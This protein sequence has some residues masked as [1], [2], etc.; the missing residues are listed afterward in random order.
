MNITNT[1]IWHY[2]YSNDGTIWEKK[3]KTVAPKR[4]RCVRR[5]LTSSLARSIVEFECVVVRVPACKNGCT[6]QSPHSVCTQLLPLHSFDVF[7]SFFHRLRHFFLHFF[8]LLH[9]HS[10]SSFISLY[11]GRPFICRSFKQNRHRKR[12]GNRY[13][14]GAMRCDA[15][16]VNFCF[17]SF[18]FSSSA[19]RAVF[20]MNISLFSSPPANAGHSSNQSPEVMPWTK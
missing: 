11:S 19:R 16:S 13:V 5:S 4:Y 12:R 10:F 3:R 6:R 7:H 14:C 9:V 1:S 20:K 8:L 15:S 17:V 2:Y 18:S